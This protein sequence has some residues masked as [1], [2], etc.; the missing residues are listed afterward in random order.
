MEFELLTTTVARALAFG[1]PLLL[2]ALGEIVAERSGVVNLG[3]EGMMM[4]GAVAGFIAA[5][6]SGTLLLGVAAA[7]AAGML[8]AALHAFLSV[9]LASNQYVSGLAI[10]IGGVGLANLLGRDWVGRP[11]AKPM[12]FITVPVL[13]D[14]PILGPALFVDQYP[15]TYVAL[16][17][18]PLLWLFLFHTRPGLTIRTVGE[19]PSAADTAGISVRWVRFLAVVFG[20]SLAGLAGSYFS[21]AYRPAWGENITNGLGWIAL[22][23]AILALWRPLRA[24]PAALLFGAFFTLSFRL[25]GVFPPELLTV[26]PYLVTV[27]ALTLIA[28]RGGRG[29]VGAP[30]ALGTPYRRGER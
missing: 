9:T 1:T 12:G 3:M 4:L 2:A 5:Q 24:V 29:A 6:A 25:Q 18:A 20:G 23:L 16:V 22:G 28:L 30:E 17:I 13:S 7:V 21:L 8:V 15:L 26:L 27:L 19:S 14:I 10:T 11:L